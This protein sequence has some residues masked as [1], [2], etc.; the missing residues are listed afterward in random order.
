MASS[1]CNSSTLVPLLGTPFNTILC[2]SDQMAYLPNAPQCSKQIYQKGYSSPRSPSSTIHPGWTV[3]P[4]PGPSIVPA[5]NDSNWEDAPATNPIT[6]STANRPTSSTHSWPKPCQSNNTNGQLANVLSQLANTLNTNQ[7]PGFNI[8]I[9]ETKAHIP[10][11]FSST[12]SDNIVAT[13]C[14]SRINDLT[15]SKALQWAIK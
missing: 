9:R 12:E 3:L 15:T 5:D 4:V 14:H 6:N 13:T 2:F 10:N 1:H 11:T 8:N 7:T